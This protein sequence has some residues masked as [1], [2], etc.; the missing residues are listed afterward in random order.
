M[1]SR[2]ENSEGLQHEIIKAI[3]TAK[4][5]HKKHIWCTLDEYS[6]GFYLIDTILMDHNERSKHQM[7]VAKNA[8]QSI[9]SFNIGKNRV[10][11]SD[12]WDDKDYDGITIYIDDA[13]FQ[14]SQSLFAFVNT[15]N[16]NVDPK[17]LNKFHS[18]TFV[19]L[20]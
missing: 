13:L 2:I 16:L 4:A 14:S 1:K 5:F 10:N 19:I 18:H 3:Y 9:Y 11:I 20:L 17:N 7:N 8:R 15:D 6:E 12:I